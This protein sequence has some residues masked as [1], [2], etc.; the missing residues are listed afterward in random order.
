MGLNVYTI[1]RQ[2]EL[3]DKTQSFLSGL[4]YKRIKYF[5]GDGYKGLPEIAPFDEI[6]VTA[7]AEQIP[8]NLLLQLKTNGKMVIPIGTQK[9]I[10]TRIRR[11]S[12]NDFE[13]ETFNECAFVPMLSDVT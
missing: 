5:Y 9:Q 1:E 10:M 12:E 13:T 2:K 4:G 3:F 11:L 8:K 7:G 6:L